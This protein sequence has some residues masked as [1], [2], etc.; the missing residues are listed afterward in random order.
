MVTVELAAK[1]VPVTVSVVPTW[2]VYGDKEVDEI[3]LNVLLAKS[4]DA[5]VAVTVWVPA[6]DFGILNVAVKEPAVSVVMVLGEV[7]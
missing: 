1:P 4:P 7:V 3:T 5:S 6:V 2:P